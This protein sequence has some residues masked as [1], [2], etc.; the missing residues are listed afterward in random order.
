M[1]I[2]LPKQPTGYQFEE[3]VAATIRSI[4]YLR[5]IGSFFRHDSRKV[6]NYSKIAPNQGWLLSNWHNAAYGLLEK[7]LAIKA[8]AKP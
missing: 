3:A 5:G 8:A 4:G 1:P 2:N 6:D 7:E